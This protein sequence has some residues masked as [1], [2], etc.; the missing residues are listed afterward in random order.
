MHDSHLEES[1]ASFFAKLENAVTLNTTLQQSLEK[2][3][4]EKDRL[5]RHNKKLRSSFLCRS[6]SENLSVDGIACP[7]PDRVL[8]RL[9]RIDAAID[10]ARSDYSTGNV[11]IKALE[12]RKEFE[13]KM[14]TRTGNVKYADW[15]KS[16]TGDK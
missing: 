1:R 2:A 13:S 5:L 7:S 4:I 15:L 16:Q 11:D 3:T 14:G 6:D 12:K 8:K 9:D 10:E